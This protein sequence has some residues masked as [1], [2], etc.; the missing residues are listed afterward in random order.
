MWRLQ[1]RLRGAVDV[2]GVVAAPGEGFNAARFAHARH[3]GDQDA[4]RSSSSKAPTG[5]A[6]W[7]CTGDTEGGM[8]YRPIQL[9]RRRPA[10][11]A[12]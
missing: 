7:L 3:A 4:R 12:L 1:G 5:G 2:D 11:G 6:V 9:P 10:L 8:K